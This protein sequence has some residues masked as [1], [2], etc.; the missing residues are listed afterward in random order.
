MTKLFT[1]CTMRVAACCQLRS[2]R[3]RS[4]VALDPSSQPGGKPEA[5]A[6][7]RSPHPSPT[8]WLGMRSFARLPAS[9]ALISAV[10]TLI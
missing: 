10:L 8:G 7:S 9:S 1:S 5:E 2:T 3:S 6:L 4:A